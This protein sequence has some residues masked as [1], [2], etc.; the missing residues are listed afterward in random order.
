VDTAAWVSTID[1]ITTEDLVWFRAS[2]GMSFPH[3]D[4]AIVPIN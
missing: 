2:R 3:K 1:P 4:A